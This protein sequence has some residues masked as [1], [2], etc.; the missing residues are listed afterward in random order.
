IG[1]VWSL[2]SFGDDIA[3]GNWLG[4]SLSGTGFAGGALEIGGWAAGSSRLVTAGRFLGAPGAVIGSGMMG[5]Q[6][7]TYI[8]E[9]T[10][11]QDTAMAGGSWVE[12]Q[13]GSMYLGAAGA[14]GTAII[15]SPYYAGKAAVGALGDLGGW[16][17]GG[18]YNLFH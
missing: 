5:W 15:T 1:T 3:S 4:A 14:A 18:I 12:R 17:G 8:N 6:A 9:N 16:I 11:I 2:S 7:G 10:G 13:T